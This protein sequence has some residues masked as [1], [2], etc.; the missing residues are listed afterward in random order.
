[1][2][3]MLKSPQMPGAKKELSS[4]PGSGGEWVNVDILL[5]KPG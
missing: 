4:Q 5:E 1:M 3:T 2:Q